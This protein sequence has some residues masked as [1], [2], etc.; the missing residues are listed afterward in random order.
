[1]SVLE[2]FAAAVRQRN[3]EYFTEILD[4]PLT[5]TTPVV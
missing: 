1:M 4:I 3:L 5:N 2:E